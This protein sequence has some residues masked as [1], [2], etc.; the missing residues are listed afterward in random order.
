MA[1]AAYRIR[2][3]D[4]VTVQ[5][6]D[7]D[8]EAAAGARIAHLM[9]VMDVVD[10][11]VVVSRWYGGIKLGPDRYGRGFL[12]IYFL[13]WLWRRRRRLMGVCVQIPVD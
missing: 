11:L 4:G 6:N 3:E 7:D 12:F 1:A 8:G 13:L 5:D 10:V 2:R 9:R